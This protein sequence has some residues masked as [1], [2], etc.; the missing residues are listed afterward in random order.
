MQH[1]S[2]KHDRITESPGP[3]RPGSPLYLAI[4]QIAANIT[5]TLDE[6]GRHQ[7]LRCAPA[8][9]RDENKPAE[10]LTRIEFQRNN[11]KEDPHENTEIDPT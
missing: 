11:S 10:G 5:K 6:S 4:S 9:R 7:Y 8:G 3:I 2:E 1:R